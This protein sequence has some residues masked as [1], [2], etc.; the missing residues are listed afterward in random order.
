MTPS[1]KAPLPVM[2]AGVPLPLLVGVVE[3]SAIA[4]D[5]VDPT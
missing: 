1:L 2:D 3:V 4:T 5:A